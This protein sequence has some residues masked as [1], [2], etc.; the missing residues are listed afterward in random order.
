MTQPQRVKIDT[1]TRQFIIVGLLCTWFLIPVWHRLS[2]ASG[3]FTRDYLI[4]Y[5]I[6]LPALWTIIWWVLSGFQGIHRLLAK[7]SH[8]IWI[9]LLLL[10]CI[11]VIASQRWAFVGANRP[12]IAAAGGVQFAITSLLICCIIAIGIKPRHFLNVIL[13]TM[14]IHVAIGG[15]QVANQSSIGLSWLGEFDLDPQRQGVGVIQSG[16]TRW[17]RPYGLTAHPNIYAGFVLVGVLA[18]L[19]W[20]M[21]E[22]RWQRWIGTLAYAFGYWGL[23]LTFSRSA[24]LGFALGAGLF[25]ILVRKSISSNQNHRRYAIL[26]A[27]ITI[28]SSGLFLTI[29]QPLVLVRA[30]AGDTESTE[31]RSLNDRAIYNQIAVEAIR[32]YPLLGVGV[33]N[34]PWYSNHYL[35][36]ETDYDMRGDNVHNIYLGIFSELGIV[37][38]LLFMGII[39]SGL[40]ISLRL[41][42]DETIYHD[43]SVLICAST[44]LLIIGLFDHYLWT[45]FHFQIL[46]LSLL[47]LAQQ[48]N[49][50]STSAH[51]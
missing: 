15:L 18:C 29:Y 12:E 43:R 36:Y 4:G 9:T 38:F 3:P 7:P 35:F 42:T 14:L 41:P 21:A 49:A 28:G 31:T 6:F 11:W 10:L 5:L 32:N 40:S 26:I 48:Q 47:A 50:A 44:A 51:I 17:L 2:Y 30:G 8:I 20:V 46:L 13:L 34:F 24:W 27:T 16:D 39:I 1:V 23:L 25:L 19:S 33:G 45:M 37:G 22:S